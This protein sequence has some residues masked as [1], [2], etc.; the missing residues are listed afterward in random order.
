MIPGWDGFGSATTQ[1]TRSSESRQPEMASIQSGRRDL[2][3]RHPRWQRG[4]LPLSYSRIIRQG[5]M[6]RPARPPIAPA[7]GRFQGPISSIAQRPR[8]AS[9]LRENPATDHLHGPPR[10]DDGAGPGAGDLGKLHRTANSGR[11]VPISHL[12]PGPGDDNLML[13]HLRENTKYPSAFDR[14]DATM[15][16]VLQVVRGGSPPRRSSWP[17]A[18]PASGATTIVSFASSRRR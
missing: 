15:N 10:P 11:S 12:R 18:S 13:A 7:A 9:R 17:M 16:Y 1:P 5:L 14:D 8:I 4:A 3:P 6:L 2:N